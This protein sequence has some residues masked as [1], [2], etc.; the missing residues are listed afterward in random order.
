MRFNKYPF[1]FFNP[2]KLVIRK[3][4]FSGK[5]SVPLPV[6]NQR[7]KL[8][9]WELWNCLRKSTEFSIEFLILVSWNG[10]NV[11]DVNVNGERVSISI[12]N[13]TAVRIFLRFTDELRLCV[14]QELLLIYYLNIKGFAHHNR[15]QKTEDNET[16]KNSIFHGA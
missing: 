16:T 11:I 13:V 1:Q 15:E 7:A 8:E 5:P 9:V 4:N 14:G 12:N 3:M 10:E 2:L 6:L